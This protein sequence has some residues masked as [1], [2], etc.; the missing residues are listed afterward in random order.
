[1]NEA[2]A[3]ALSERLFTEMVGGMSLLVVYVG[4]R[5]ALFKEMAESGPVTVMQLARRTNLSVRY[6]REWLFAVASSEYVEAD[7]HGEKF[8]LSEE[9]AAVLADEDSPFFLGAYPGM[10]QGL[11]IAINPLLEA[12]KSG[13]GVRYE[14]YGKHFR[15]AIALTGKPMFQH[16]YAQKWI[17]AM[18]DVEA[19]LK[20][21]ASVAD[22]GCGDGWSSVYLAK[23]FEKVTVDGID[24]DEASIAEARRNAEQ[25]GVTDRIRFHACAIEK[26]EVEAQYD[27]VTSFECLH[28]LSY[29]VQALSR[30]REIA[31]PEGTVFIADMAGGDSFADNQ[32]HPMGRFFHKVSVLHCLPQAMVFPESVGTGTA[33]SESEIR[34]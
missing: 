22:V 3:E 28:D 13:G 26:F 25:R 16:D 19:R 21:G 31:N 24:I 30:M 14:D 5:L 6:V 8:K 23:N 4:H 9:H 34:K 27:L 29:P 10:L 32:N 12:F 33:I 18:P 15:E 11:A 17:P 2:R 7:A 1:M 20:K